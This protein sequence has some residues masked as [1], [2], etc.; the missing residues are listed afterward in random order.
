M[1]SYIHTRVHNL[2]IV[3][4]GLCSSVLPRVYITY[5]YMGGGTRFGGLI[6]FVRGEELTV[7]QACIYTPVRLFNQRT[8]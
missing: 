6:A 1:Y 4:R 3:K 2:D 5:M 8:R 7:R